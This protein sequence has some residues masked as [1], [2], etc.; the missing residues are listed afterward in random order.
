MIGPHHRLNRPIHASEKA[1]RRGDPLI[2]WLLRESCDQRF[3]EI[4][5]DEIVELARFIP[6]ALRWRVRHEAGADEDVGRRSVF[7]CPSDHGLENASAFGFDVFWIDSV[8]L[9]YDIDVV[10]SL[11]D[12]RPLAVLDLPEVCDSGF[13][14]RRRQDIR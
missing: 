3:V 9:E 6:P 7:A 14:A 12:C 13:L 5:K 1:Q 11:D 8:M 4:E 2:A 10:A